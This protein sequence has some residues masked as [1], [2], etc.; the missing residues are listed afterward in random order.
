VSGMGRGGWVDGLVGVLV[1]R[2]SLI[3]C[4]PAL[5]LPV[6]PTFVCATLADCDMS[7]MAPVL[8]AGDG[9]SA[10][11]TLAMRVSDHEQTKQQTLGPA[12]ALAAEN[13]QLRRWVGGWGCIVPAC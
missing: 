8:A 2:S 11:G 4:P 3:C 13:E 9:L 7:V 5:L 1:G 12:G 10:L 6:L